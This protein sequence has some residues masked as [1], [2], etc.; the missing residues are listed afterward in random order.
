MRAVRPDHCCDAALNI[1]VAIVCKVVMKGVESECCQTQEPKFGAKQLFYLSIEYVIQIK[2]S[3]SVGICLCAQIWTQ[4][5]N[6]ARRKRH[7]LKLSFF[8]HS[9]SHIN[10]QAHALPLTR[11]AFRRT[12][13]CAAR[14]TLLRPS[15]TQCAPSHLLRR[16]FHASRRTFNQESNTNQ[17]SYGGKHSGQEYAFLPQEH[18]DQY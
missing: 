5:R 2:Q 7:F 13:V 14:A 1:P 4:R 6:G 10:M 3:L 12:P 17:K 8:I 16:N 9:T 18:E 15:T 11:V